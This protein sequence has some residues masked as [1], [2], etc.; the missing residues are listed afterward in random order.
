[1]TAPTL[2]REEWLALRATG[3]GSSDAAAACG[4]SN[5]S[6]AEL[7]LR[8]RGV[9]P[10][11]DFTDIEAVQ[12]G[13]LLQP[14]IV[15]ATAR[16]TK[17]RVL[18]TELEGERRFLERE[19]QASGETE[20]MG[21]VDG[22]EPFLRSVKYPHM[23][24]TLDGVAIDDNSGLVLIEAKNCGQ[25]HSRDWDEEQGHAPPKFDIQ[26]GHQ[27]AVAP[28]FGAGV[29]AGLIGGNSLRVLRRE[30]VQIEFTIEAIITLEAEIW[31]CVESGEFPKYD[32]SES[33]IRALRAL[34]PMDT[35]ETITLPDE[36]MRWHEELRELLLQRAPMESR[37]KTL[38][39]NI[40]AR[41]NGATAG[42][43]PDGSGQYTN[44][45]Q[46]RREYVVPAA[47]FPVLRF[48]KAANWRAGHSGPD[49]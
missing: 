21:W 43:L 44:R 31:R 24:A 20:V 3:L 12:W 46:E 48:V 9:M 25:Y 2:T 13:S 16:R 35:G 41:L 7:V 37:I 17:L 39:R 33:H 1:M 8:K 10:D 18:P 27:L 40:E 22:R 5:V 42:I 23:S 30:R 32:G 29:L 45:H 11:P 4:E 26:V 6:P 47:S 14:A 15:H 49:T 28:A 19:I 38:R 36:A 34:H